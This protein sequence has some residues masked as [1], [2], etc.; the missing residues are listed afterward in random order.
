M[1]ASAGRRRILMLLG[2]NPF[3]QDERVA[4]ESASLVE[5][6]Y[7]VAVI[8]PRAQGQPKRESWR[9]VEVYRYR[10][11]FEP[12]GALGY[13]IEYVQA[14]LAA[15]FLSVRVAIDGRFQVIHAHN[16][17]DTY[18]VVAAPYKAL[19]VR[20][21][22]DHH[23]LSPEMYEAR[24]SG[25]SSRALKW[26]LTVFERLSYRLA[27]YA[28]A[29]NE[30][31]REMAIERG[32]MSPE[33]VAVVRNGPDLDRVHLVDPDPVLRER[34]ANLLGY[35]GV[36]GYQDGLDHLLRAVRHLVFDLGRTDVLA[37]LIGK[38][39][40]LEEMKRLSAELGLSEH[41]WFTGR[42]SDE[43]LLSMLSTVDICLDPDPS[44]PFTDRSTMIKMAEYM[45]LGKPIVAFD[46]PEHRVTAQDAAVYVRPNDELEFA[47]AIADLIDDPAR[48]AAMGAAGRRRV[49]DALSWHHSVPPLLAAYEQLIGGPTKT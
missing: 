19:R 27:D 31:Y 14:T 30:S 4:Q 17:P 28:I 23:D 43:A 49:D 24:F 10:Q 18:W 34:A 37:V 42:V 1:K 39:D 5:A 15:L 6:G 25:R 35:V 26:I 9:G 36:M 33:R 32:R 22:Y 47:R 44:N 16:P 40:A 21:I 8:C 2:N 11:P 13:A 48:R 7:R 41:V 46:L 3:P 38:G 12:Q 29:T 20:F 45:T